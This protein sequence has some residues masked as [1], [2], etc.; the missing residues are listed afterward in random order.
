MLRAFVVAGT[1]AGLAALAASRPQPE[2]VPAPKA[3]AAAPP[4]PSG[5][6]GILLRVYA[7][8]AEDRVLAVAGG[9]TFYSILA[10]FPAIAALISL[11]GLFAD[12]G[13]VER[14]VNAMSGF[15]PGGAIDVI[16]GQ[17]HR[18]AANGKGA[19]GVG[20]FVGLAIALWSANSGIKALFDALNVAYDAREERSFLKL[21]A[22]SLS[23]TLGAIVFGLLAIVAVVAIPTLL[24]L[25]AG[26]S[27]AGR[28]ILALARWPAIWLVAALALAVLYRFGPSSGPR[29]WRWISWGSATASLLWLIVS[30]LFSWYV[31]H[32]GSYNATYGSLGA[33]IG[34]MTWMW[35]SIAVI[36]LGAEL[37]SE[38]E[39][40]RAG[41][42]RAVRR[43]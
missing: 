37:N 25:S 24:N 17:L 23:F 9:A 8:I 26:G 13:D 28:T 11:Y 4:E 19:L 30:A 42:R 20:F 29:A 5:W 15:L 32:F 39:R 40:A 12:P 1:A 7:S 27:A 33:V 16:G 38:I 14:Q 21:N 2:R 22:I 18:L 10:L 36:M 31:S 43:A 41:L 3:A 35:L 6:K 34:F